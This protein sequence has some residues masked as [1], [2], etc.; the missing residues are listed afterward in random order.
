MQVDGG[1]GGAPSIN[2][3]DTF[4]IA[5]WNVQADRTKGPG[6]NGSDRSGMEECVRQLLSVHPDII[7]LLEMQ[8][9]KLAA[10]ENRGKDMPTCESLSQAY[11]YLP[12]RFDS[13]KS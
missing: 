3:C 12:D 8:R 4:T 13:L 1:G 7:V 11:Q 6:H 5:S 9:C 10:R 2:L